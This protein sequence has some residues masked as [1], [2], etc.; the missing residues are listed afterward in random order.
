[1]NRTSRAGTRRPECEPNGAGSGL[2]EVDGRSAETRPVEEPR[3]PLPTRL[4]DTAPLPARA[5]EELRAGVAELG[6]GDLPEISLARLEGHL[7]LLLAWNR[8]VN[9]TAI[10]DPAEAVRLHVLDSLT[11]VPVLRS[12]GVDGILDLGSGGGYPGLPLA[13]AL[14]A[15]RALLVDSI[16]KKAAFLRTAVAAL[17]LAGAVDVASTRAETLAVDRVH[18]GRWPAVVARAV[19]DLAELA[20]LAL[21]L[22]CVGGVLVAWKRGPLDAELA[23]AA[24]AIA[25]LGGGEPAVESIAVPGL[26]SHRL[27]IVPKLRAT[28]SRFPRDPATRARD[29][30]RAIAESPTIGR[31]AAARPS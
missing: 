11:A 8:A 28:P 30:R 9:L 21:P 18:R 16:G 25:A 29:R 7:R 26:V 1:V 13:V 23:A 4:G 31:A 5:R 22:V 24:D 6:L 12:R 19:A 27:V 2:R 15:R 17:D 14:P 10:R 20:E 3:A